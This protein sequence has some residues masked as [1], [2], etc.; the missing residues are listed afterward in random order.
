MD[1]HKK[2]IYMRCELQNNVK[3][4]LGSD[5]YQENLKFVWKVIAFWIKKMYNI[6]KL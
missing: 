5:E 1:N 6:G 3:Q 2:Q 4:H